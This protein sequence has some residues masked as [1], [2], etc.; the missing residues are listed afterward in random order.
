MREVIFFIVPFVWII[1]CI[2]SVICLEKTT[3]H[4]LQI[5]NKEQFFPQFNF[6]LGHT[7]SSS[8]GSVL[9]LMALIVLK[10]LHQGCGTPEDHHIPLVHRP[11]RSFWQGGGSTWGTGVLPRK[12]F[13]IYMQDGGIWEPFQP[14]SDNGNCAHF[15]IF[16]R[17][18]KCHCSQLR[19]IFLLSMKPFIRS[20][21][22]HLTWDLHIMYVSINSVYNY[23]FETEKK[24][25]KQKTRGVSTW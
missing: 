17:D 15:L 6:H 2:K 23:M 16:I 18:H 3:I 21:V 5:Y 1:I 4:N 19:F 14:Y 12:F 22:I 20:I 25:F 13:K 24:I 8:G 10:H 7:H 11:V 9:V